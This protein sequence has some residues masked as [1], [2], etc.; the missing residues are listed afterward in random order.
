MVTNSILKQ[1]LGEVMDE[2]ATTYAC[3]KAQVEAFY[4][5]IIAVCYLFPQSAQSG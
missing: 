1:V 4:Q 2:S 5:L 3:Q